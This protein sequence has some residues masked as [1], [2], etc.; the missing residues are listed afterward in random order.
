MVSLPPRLIW[1]FAAAGEAAAT[2]AGAA[3]GE[4]AA[5]ATDV[6]DAAAL[7]A[8][9]AGFVAVFAPALPLLFLLLLHASSAAALRPIEVRPPV[10]NAV[11]RDSRLP[12]TELQ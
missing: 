2:D 7:D 9:A 1:A 6:A 8:A 10:R 5:G 4:P 3:A 12:R 11:R